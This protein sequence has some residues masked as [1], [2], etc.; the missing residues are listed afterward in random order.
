M[1]SAVD[2]PPIYPFARVLAIVRI[3]EWDGCGMPAVPDRRALPGCATVPIV[4]PNEYFER[5]DQVR[6]ENFSFGSIQIDG[7]TYAHDV[8]IVQFRS[9]CSTSFQFPSTSARAQTLR[10][11]V[12][13][14]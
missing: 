1:S 5:E 10:I 8:V 14:E 13:D 11:G 4:E 6:I 9:V 12:V 2:V 7:R 3:V